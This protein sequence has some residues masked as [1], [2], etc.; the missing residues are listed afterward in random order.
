MNTRTLHH[1]L[2]A[3]A[4]CLLLSAAPGCASQAMMVTGFI[5][6]NDIEELET[7]Q[8]ALTPRYE[9]RVAAFQKEIDA[10]KADVNASLEAKDLM[11]SATGL[12]SLYELTHPCGEEDCGTYPCDDMCDAKERSNE[13]LKPLNKA[14]V[15]I[16]REGVDDE[17]GFIRS[18]MSALLEQGRAAFEAG[19]LERVNS[20]VDHLNENLPLSS[21]T[22][23][24]Y[25]ELTFDTKKALIDQ[26]VAKAAA[27]EATDPLQASTG[28]S[29]ASKLSADL[30]EDR[31]AADYEAKASS[32][33]GD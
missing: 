15:F 25:S 24:G 30:G 14:E 28:Y 11:A 27:D 20:M 17:A 3:A 23:R 9:A 7:Q 32:L 21:R 22:R 18:S 5:A 19:E 12:R 10:L 31:Q 13:D 33:R 6:G 29:R 1:L 8:R 4:S 16:E 26:I 2:G